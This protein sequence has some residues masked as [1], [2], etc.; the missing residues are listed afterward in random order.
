MRFRY[1]ADEQ[2]LHRYR[3]LNALARWTLHCPA[4]ESGELRASTGLRIRSAVRSVGN[5]ASSIPVKVNTIFEDSPIGLEKWLPVVVAAGKRQE[6]GLA[7]YKISSRYRRHPKEC[8]VHASSRSACDAEQSFVKLGGPRAARSR[9]TKHS[10]AAIPRRCTRAAVSRYSG[11]R[12]EVLSNWRRRD[13]AYLGKV[14]GSWECSTA[15]PARFAPSGPNV[16]R[17]N[18][19]ECDSEIISLKG[20]RSTPMVVA[21]TTF[22]AKTTSTRQ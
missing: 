19:S 2:V 16:P 5:A 17:E 9:P 7:S 3:S 18:F 8:V 6:W 22:S 12:S 20:Q 15:R 1:F 13:T 21:A 10:S 14:P 4:C 11:R